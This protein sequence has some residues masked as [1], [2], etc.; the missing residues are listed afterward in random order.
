MNYIWTI[1][2]IIMLI[3]LPAPA[4]AIDNGYAR[5]V[6]NVRGL[7]DYD[8]HWND[9]FPPG[10]I[11]K[12]YAEADGVNHRRE[13]AVDY[14]FIIKDANNNI[15]NTAS[16]SNRYE[17]YRENDFI[18]YSIEV[19]SI[20][21]D[22]VY[23][24]EVHI[25]DLLNDSLMDDYYRDLRSSYLNESDR[26]DIPVMN[27]SNATGPKQQL[28]IDKV[29]YID[30]YSNKYPADRFRAE[31]IRLDRTSVAPD[32]PVEVRANVINTF[33]D[34][35]ST[36]FSLLLDN[37][38]VD[39]TTIEIEGYGTRQVVFTVSS[40]IEGNHNI[41]IV[42]T[43]PNTIGLNLAAV[44]NI[45]IGR[46]VEGP[47]TF[48]FKDIQID[49][50]S[51]EPGRTVIISVTVENKGKEG[52]QPVT[53]Y[54]NDV[55]EE[56]R[57]VHLDFLETKDVKFNVTR[58]ELG[59]YKAT[60]GNSNLSKIFFVET[61]TPV[62]TPTVVPGIEAKPQLKYIFGLSLLIIFIYIL[63]VYFKKKLK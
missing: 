52:Y 61:I 43:G 21:E 63:R 6:Y 17:D 32:V 8:L 45:N 62:P 14:I 30:K 60:I 16:F 10:S 38:K 40:K 5:I 41:E 33:Y 25:F 3:M 39:N 36:S 13:V 15:V 48:E 12:I 9:K 51:V 24:A 11:V 57:T 37:K 23:N 59:A 20:W 18:T 46:Q 53:L 47:T 19:P 22:G 56:E 7:Q 49:N 42:P 27:R 44:L 29:F 28:E 35:G 2:L 26:P 1:I 55:Q 4:L 34:K 54:I 58:M 50:L 31:N